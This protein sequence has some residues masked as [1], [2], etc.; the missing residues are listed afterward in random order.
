MKILITNSNIENI[1]ITLY[2]EIHIIINFDNDISNLLDKLNSKDTSNKLKEDNKTKIIFYFK[3]SDIFLNTKNLLILSNFG[4]LIFINENSF[5]Y[6]YLIFKRKHYYTLFNNNIN[7]IPYNKSFN[8]IYN[9]L[10]FIIELIKK[11][12]TE[13]NNNKIINI[14]IYN[15]NIYNKLLIDKY[16]NTNLKINL[17]NNN[18]KLKKNFNAEKCE[19]KFLHITKNAGTLI[20]NLGNEINLK[21][22]R[23]DLQLN[24]KN[25]KSEYKHI[26]TDL[27]HLP[28]H[29]FK[30]EVYYNNEDTNINNVFCIVRNPYDRFISEL[31]CNWNGIYNEI[32]KNK[33]NLYNFNN[34]I[35]KIIFNQNLHTHYLPQSNLVIYHD[36]TKED[37]IYLKKIK[38]IIKYENINEEFV[39]LMNLYDIPLTLPEKHSNKSNKLFNLNCISTYNLTYINEYYNN[40]FANFNYKIIK[41]MFLNNNPCVIFLLYN[42]LTELFKLN[43]EKIIEKQYQTYIYY[44]HNNEKKEIT[45]FIQELNNDKNTN[46]IFNLVQLQDKEYKHNLVFNLINKLKLISSKC[47]EDDISDDNYIC[48]LNENIILNKDYY[49]YETYFDLIPLFSNKINMFL[50]NSTLD[51]IDKNFLITKKTNINSIL[52]NLTNIVNKN[53]DIDIIKS[54]KLGLI[55]IIK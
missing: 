17:Y 40:D 45:T 6:R 50:N 54:I 4:K 46:N 39:N 42:G 12:S 28:F 25:L 21:W 35:K 22:G 38:H 2:S 32:T 44:L 34:Y 19:L 31:F 51:I 26:N 37:Q 16:I 1:N 30:N 43:I 47:L 53:Q 9:Y 18:D 24:N 48:W 52:N 55:Q 11:K 10:N 23:F 27:Y 3:N 33:I 5:T 7:I 8:I 36:K 29:Y 41:P 13:T 15:I 14:D 20:E 49:C